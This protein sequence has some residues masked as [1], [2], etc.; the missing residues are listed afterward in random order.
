MS[1]QEI[2][3]QLEYKGSVVYSGITLPNVDI[4][5]GLTDLGKYHLT[6][7]SNQQLKPM[8]EQGLSNKQ[9]KEK[10]K[11]TLSDMPA[12]PSLK[13]NQASTATR[14]DKKTLFLEVTN[15][16]E[17]QSYL[18]LLTDKLG[19]PKLT[20]FFH[21]SVANE[22]G[23][24]FK[25]IGDINASDIKKAN[26]I[27]KRGTSKK[28]V[29]GE[30]VRITLMEAKPL[31]GQSL[32]SDEYLVFVEGVSKIY[33]KL[34]HGGGSIANRTRAT[35]TKILKSRGLLKVKKVKS[36]RGQPLPIFPDTM[37]ETRVYTFV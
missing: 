35:I 28:L 5:E 12:I 33:S 24:P 21:V 32:V 26:T 23:N 36:V 34:H 31:K 9:V 15:Q 29:Y 19:I 10:I 1:W 2:L 4:P 13:F 14:E 18:N 7:L 3:K 37:K 8:K 25:S 11:L 20:R 6:L 17:L 22:E 30:L 27:L 16:K